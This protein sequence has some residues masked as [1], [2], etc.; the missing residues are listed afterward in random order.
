MK[1]FLTLHWFISSSLHFFIHI[2]HSLLS[3]SLMLR[4][5]ERLLCAPTKLLNTTIT[6]GKNFFPLFSKRKRK[7]NACRDFFFF[8]FLLF[9]RTLIL[10]CRKMCELLSVLNIFTFFLS[11]SMAELITSERKENEKEH[12]K[13]ARVSWSEWIKKNFTIVFFS[14]L[15][16]LLK[17]EK[18]NFTC[19]IEFKNELRVYFPWRYIQLNRWR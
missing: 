5:S 4:H 9:Y 8:F 13:F 3:L 10:S 2:F 6:N 1:N 16:F 19:T 12:T 18:V 15:F 7:K 14:V 17:K 11:F